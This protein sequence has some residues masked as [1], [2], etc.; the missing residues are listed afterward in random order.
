M[1]TSVADQ[2]WAYK[3]N[4]EMT[5]GAEIPEARAREF[6]A[7]GR[8]EEIADPMAMLAA[9]QATASTTAAPAQARRK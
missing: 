7:A 3:R 8:A 1:L 2:R 9:A 4:Q 6:I 5:V